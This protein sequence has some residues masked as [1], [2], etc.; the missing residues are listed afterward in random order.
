MTDGEGQ[1][2]GWD[3]PRD[4]SAMVDDYFE[5]LRVARLA[6]PRA[7]GARVESGP[8][9]ADSVVAV[10]HRAVVEAKRR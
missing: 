3:L 10:C 2:D 9:D 4:A 8:H 5:R 6:V 7:R 1:P